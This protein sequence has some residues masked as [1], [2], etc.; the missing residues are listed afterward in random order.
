MSLSETTRQRIEDIISQDKI[1]LFMKGTPQQPQC[2][3]GQLGLCCR[4]CNMGPCHIDP[5]GKG[6]RR[7]VCGADADT[8]T[9]RHLGRMIAAG[10]AAH[11][12]HGRDVVHTL[13]MAAKEKGGYRINGQNYFP[14][15]SSD[16]FT[17]TGIASWYGKKFH[18]RTTANG[19]KYNMYGRT[20]AHKTLPFGTVVRVTNLGNGRTADVR[21]NDRGPFVHGRI[22]DLTHTL[23]GELEGHHADTEGGDLLG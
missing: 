9:A 10:T 1:V 13:M 21:I 6:P 4:I 8:F 3:F 14:I 5:F 23:A 11:S 19:E 2:G 20:G 18:G 16:G 15:K 17:Q 7:G 12:D 22:I